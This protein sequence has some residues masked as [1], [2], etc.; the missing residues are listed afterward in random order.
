MHDDAL[1]QDH[2]FS[3]KKQSNE[4]LEPLFANS[5]VRASNGLTNQK[6][7]TQNQSSGS[8]ISPQSRSQYGKFQGKVKG[9]IETIKN[10]RGGSGGANRK[11]SKVKL[12]PLPTKPRKKVPKR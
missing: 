4:K 10:S 8:L 7:M 1:S 12:S 2:G 3:K 11:N 5:N 9:R 6:Y